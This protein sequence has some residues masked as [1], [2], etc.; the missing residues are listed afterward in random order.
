MSASRPL[1]PSGRE[2]DAPLPEGGE[3]AGDSGSAAAAAGL[4]S[5]ALDLARD[6]VAL[7]AAELRLAALSGM[8]M[9]MLVLVTAALIVVGWTFVAA[10]AAYVLV[11][12]G[13]P[14]PAAGLI[15]AAVHGVAAFLLWRTVVRLSRSLTLPEL[16]RSVLSQE[17]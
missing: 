16:R 7:A 6:I 13:L 3:Q 1:P 10:V 15:I 11:Q 2:D 5:G 9:L 17:E 8:T 4:V 14:W 12:V